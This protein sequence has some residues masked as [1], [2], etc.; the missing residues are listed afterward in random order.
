MKMRRSNSSKLQ[1]LASRYLEL[2]TQ[3]KQ[4]EAEVAR[5]KKELEGIKDNIK[6]QIGDASVCV[7]PF[8]ITQTK[9]DRDGHVVDPYSFI[10]FAVFRS[11]EETR[12]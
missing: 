1:L 7:G 3:K 8:V 9:E 12:T 11:S 5:L 6:Y 10:R 4:L 2:H